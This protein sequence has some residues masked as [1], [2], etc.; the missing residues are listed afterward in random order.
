M[1]RAT[2]RTVLTVLTVLTV[3]VTSLDLLAAVAM[4]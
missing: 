3:P 1:L 4:E 2:L